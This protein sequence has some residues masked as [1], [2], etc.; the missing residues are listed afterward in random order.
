MHLTYK[1]SSGSTSKPE[2]VCS[3]RLK[4][5]HQSVSLNLSA[6]AIGLK[7]FERCVYQ[8]VYAKPF[9]DT[10]EQTTSDLLEVQ[11]KNTCYSRVKY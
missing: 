4:S 1:L 10:T 2:F 11:V 6:R 5:Q 9:K 8:P 3:Y 7:I